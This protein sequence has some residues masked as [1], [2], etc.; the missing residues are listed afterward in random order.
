M[1]LYSSQEF[2]S[3]VLWSIL[4]AAWTAA[5]RG[6]PEHTESLIT[7][8]ELAPIRNTELNFEAIYSLLDGNIKEEGLS[9]TA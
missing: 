2:A 5:V 6:D 9:I 7:A 8:S 4:L 1:L 3:F